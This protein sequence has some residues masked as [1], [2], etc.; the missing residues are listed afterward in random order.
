MVNYLYD[1]DSVEVRHQ[2][3]MDNK[4]S[5]SSAGRRLLKPAP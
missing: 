2:Q 4:V 3:F 1:I 5:H